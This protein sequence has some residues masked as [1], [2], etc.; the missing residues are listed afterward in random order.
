MNKIFSTEA[1]IH[2]LKSNKLIQHSNIPM[3]YVP[4]LPIISILNGNLCMKVPYLKYKVTGEVDKTFVYPIKFIVTISIPEETI[5]GIEDLSFNVSFANVE[6]NNPI[7]LFRH[8]AIKNLNKEAY[9]NLRK[10]LYVEY[11]KIVCYLT[12]GGAYTLTDESHFKTL[13][14]VILE[15]SLHPFYRA[16][17][18]DFSNKYLISNN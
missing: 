16:I 9:Y 1:L 18:S 3:G 14:N 2:S 8:D 4:G 7:G 5:I 15:P 10:S 13:F 17:D 6:F 11:D 12:N